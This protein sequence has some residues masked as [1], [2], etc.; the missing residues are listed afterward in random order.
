MDFASQQLAYEQA[1]FYRDQI[2]TLRRIQAEHGFEAGQGIID[3]FAVAKKGSTVCVHGLFIRHGRIIASK[4][5][6]SNDKLQQSEAYLLTAFLP[7]F[8]LANEQ[9]Q[10]PHELIVS[11]SL[12]MEEQR[13]LEQVLDR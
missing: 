11:H 2:V 10:L 3:V 5:Y 8:Y 12:P 6:F 9:R 7:Q 1:A 13:V 4:S